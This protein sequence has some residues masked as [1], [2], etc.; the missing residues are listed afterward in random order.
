MVPLMQIKWKRFKE[1]IT[2][3]DIVMWV[4]GGAILAMIIWGSTATLAAGRYS[5]HHWFDFVIFGLAQ[6]SIYALIAM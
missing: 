4:I 6:G 1:R 2:P 5:A 3:T